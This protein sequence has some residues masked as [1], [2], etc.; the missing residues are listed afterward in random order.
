MPAYSLERIRVE[1]ALGVSGTVVW[2]E[3]DEVREAVA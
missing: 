2:R 3:V 1:L